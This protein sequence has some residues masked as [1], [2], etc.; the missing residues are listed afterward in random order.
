MGSSEREGIKHIS[1]YMKRVFVM[2]V[3][4]PDKDTQ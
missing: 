1:S 4:S 3:K 2:F